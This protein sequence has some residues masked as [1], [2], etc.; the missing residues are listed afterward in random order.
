VS[1]EAGSAFEDARA[2][3]EARARF[4]LLERVAYLNAGTF[5]PLSQATIDAVDAAQQADIAAGRAGTPWFEALLASR[6]R[7]RAALAQEVGAEPAQVA[8]TRSTTDAINIVI[9]GLRLGPGDEVVTTD[10]EHFGLIG[11]LVAAGAAIKVAHL[12]GAGPGDALELI[13]DEVTPQTKLIAISAVSWLTGNALPAARLREATGV[14]VLVDGAQSVGAIPVETQSV[15]YLTISG[16]KWLCGPDSTGGLV[17]REPEALGLSQVS[18]FAAETYDLEL[19]TFEPRAGA[20]RFDQGWIPGPALAGLEAALADLPEWR[21]DRARE[22][23]ERLR[24]LLI[25]AGLDVV[26][27]ADQA[28]L[29]SFRPVGDPSETVK[30]LAAQ[31]VAVREIPGS[32]LVRASVGWWTSEDDLGRLLDGLS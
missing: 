21:F 9:G 6:D 8:L 16:Q 31:D 20:A 7:V 3:E 2:F 13:G 28:T 15:D 10:V 14:P 26:T 19:A 12:R 22:T 30:R 18:Y 5:G 11:P 32:G 4:P 1:V 17:V 25:E 29:V 23:A 24:A 27:G